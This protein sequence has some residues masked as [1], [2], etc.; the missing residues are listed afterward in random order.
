MKESATPSCYCLTCGGENPGS[1]AVCRRCRRELAASPQQRRQGIAFLLNELE[2]LRTWG[3]VSE[4]VYEDLHQRYEESLLAAIEES[5]VAAKVAPGAI[6]Q[7]PGAPE[8]GPTAVRAPTV[9]LKKEG[10][11]WLAEQQANLLL[12]LGA[13]LIGIG[14]LIFVG[15]SEQ[16]IGGG[17][18][19]G[20]LVA[21][22]LLLLGTGIVCMRFPRVRQAGLVFFAIGALMV[23]LSFVGAYAFFFADADMDP[24][25]L[26][27]GGSLASA[28]FYGA[29]SMLGI[30]R[31]YTF[32]AAAAAVSAFWAMLVLAD[33]PPE[34]YPASS[35]AVAAFLA[36]P[37][38]FRLGRLSDTFGLAGGLAA[39]IVV[40]AAM[41]LALGMTDPGA[42]IWL[43][44][45]LTAAF[46]YGAAALGYVGPPY[47]VP[48]AAA[49]VSSLWA[50]LALV[51]APVEAYPGSFVALAVLL[52]L[53]SMLRLGRLTGVFGE[54]GQVSAHIVSAAA[55]SAALVIAAVDPVASG[56]GPVTRAYLPATGAIAVLF[57]GA[58]AYWA[59][60]SQPMSEPFLS[61]AALAVTGG[62][63]VTIVYAAGFGEQ[64]Y[65]PA[66]AI[67]G[68]LYA[69]GSEGFGPRWFG[70]RYLGW[71]AL[72]AVT[73]SWLAF[74]GLYADFPRQGA[75]VHLAAA[76]F[77]LIAG[78]L[79]KAEIPL[80]D[81][82][83]PGG[84]ER[85][86]RVLLSVPLVYSAGISLAV[87][88]FYLLSS[89][90]A[91]E[92]AEGSDLAWPYFGLSLGVAA[93]A[94]TLRWWWPSIRPHAYVIAVA[95]SLFA[96]L[97]SLENE[98]ALP[99]VL[100][101]YA[102]ISLALTL[103]EREPLAL[104]V[105]ATYGFFA[106]LAGWAHYE[107]A[108]AYLPLALSAMGSALFVAYAVLRRR[109][110][111]WAWV[112]LA[113]ASTY[114]LAAPVAGW[115][116]LYMLAE[117]SGFVG[118]EHFEETLLYQ[119]SA[120]SVLTVAL[121][122][123]ALAWI[124]RRV[125]VAAGATA[126]MMVALLLEIGHFKPENVQAY[127]APLGVYLLAMTLIIPRV[128][129]LTEDLRELIGPA[130]LLA[131]ILIMAPSLV[132]SFD[133]DAWQYGLIMLGEG[134][135]SVGL[136]MLYRRIWLLGA[137]TG[138]VVLDGLHYLFFA[139]GPALP[140]WAILSIAGTAV[141]A[142]GTA[143]LLGRD[144]WMRWHRTLTAWW[145]QEPLSP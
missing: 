27:L 132:Q 3:G 112:S 114:A 143:I 110:D 32:P 125:E 123:V 74:E 57:Y 124:E 119:T 120:A 68:W 107:P 96:S 76:A 28:L 8:P 90:P 140:N 105:P 42:Q 104:W 91:A 115:V 128:C 106:L 134:L 101:L 116:R 31:W 61:V 108:D 44:V 65:G 30:S 14:A 37:S 85:T 59:S 29:V 13:F 83:L 75:G 60:R 12:Y 47:A 72:G 22:T 1:A 97:S 138:F 17:V 139:G 56:L 34:A 144:Q 142:A 50:L 21:Y 95:L 33:A 81:P 122:M 40:P 66:V 118:T 67:V 5:S 63:A 43:N 46:F 35:V 36:A 24:T 133:E 71:M 109:N 18:K 103:W 38:L 70:Q 117:P 55:V 73:V 127:T 93:V 78:R 16:A 53:P 88:F 54:V 11:S 111:R 113:L 102:G 69:L 131:A 51:D 25:G 129:T 45:S 49:L 87:G 39:H 92:G 9:E 2:M 137:A 4:A 58:Q 135:A 145:N 77:C 100:V 99:L 52:A 48:T 10:P 130:E 141:M 79:S 80:S 23:P 26:W 62:T 84:S 20:L 64:W 98:G 94:A 121:L 126:V 41:A 136:A 19:M 7:V 6:A 89:L 82:A 15:Y 86:Y